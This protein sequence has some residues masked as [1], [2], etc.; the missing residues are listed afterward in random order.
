MKTVLYLAC[1]ILMVSCQSG[2]TTA[3]TTMK[4]SALKNTQIQEHTF[5]KEM[6]EDAY[7]PEFLVDKC[8]EVLLVLCQQIEEKEPANLE[9]LYALSHAATDQ[10]ND[11]QE[12]FFENDSEIETVA[13]ECLA[14]DFLFIA[15]AY[16]FEADVEALIATRDW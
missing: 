12:E 11:L 9:E 4:Q 16:G 14:M 7:F 3:S 8:K 6:Y 15:E 2:S 1:F 13:R 10:L 5:L